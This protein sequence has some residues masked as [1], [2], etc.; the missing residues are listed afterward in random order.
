MQ[1]GRI[2][3]MPSCV[4]YSSEECGDVPSASISGWSDC[5]DYEFNDMTVTILVWLRH[6]DEDYENLNVYAC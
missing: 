5:C 1:L 6:Y 4:P 2:W 3:E